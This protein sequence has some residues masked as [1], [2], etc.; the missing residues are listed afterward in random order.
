MP[1][2]KRLCHIIIQPKL[3]DFTI[4]TNSHQKEILDDQIARLFYACNL[5]FSLAENDVFKK[6]ISMLRTDYTPPRRKGLAGGIL[7]KIFNEV[8][9]MTASAPWRQGCYSIE[10]WVE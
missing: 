6:T 3:N 7:E 2:E 4:K 8:T 9:T 1:P 10:G 5:T